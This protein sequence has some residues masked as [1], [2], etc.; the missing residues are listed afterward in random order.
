MR[1]LILLS[2]CIFIV[3]CT[4]ELPQIKP[5]STKN[6]IVSNDFDWKTSKEITVNVHQSFTG[7]ITIS[8]DNDSILFYK[9]Y[10]DGTE[11]GISISVTI[12][13]YLSNLK[14][15]DQI[16]TPIS[17]KV[18]LVTLDNP[19]NAPSKANSAIIKNYSLHLNGTTDWVSI[20][21]SQNLVFPNAFS[22]EAWVKAEH[23]QTAKII[24]KG[25]WDGFSIGEDLYKGWMTSVCN[26][27]MRATTLIWDKGQPVLNRWYHLAATYDGSLLKLYVD[28]VLVN[29]TAIKEKMNN[30]KRIIDIGCD[31]GNQKFFKGYMDNI[32]IW[33]TTLT[34][35]DVKYTMNT[36]PYGTGLLA[37][38]E[39]NEGSGTTVYNAVSNL[40]T[41]NLIGSFS[42]DLGYGI[43]SDGDGILNNYDDFPNDPLRAFSNKFPATGLG[44]LA[45]ED[46]WPGFG[47]FDFNDLVVEYQFD[48]ITNNKNKL[49]ETN[50]TFIVKAA[51]S[52][53][54]NGFGFQL[55][56]D[57]P[58]S[59]MTVT[60]SKLFGNI[61]STN[62]KGWE[63][64]QNKPTC[65]VFDNAFKCIK[66]PG[67]G[68]GVN[69]SEN[70][71]FVT[72]DTIKLHISYTPDKYT[73]ANLNI[74]RFNPFLIVNQIRSKEIHLADY[75]PTALVDKSYFDTYQDATD[76]NSGKYYRSST[77]LPWAINFY[78]KFDY[79]YEKADI[80]KA[81][82]KMASWAS[83]NGLN[84]SDWYKNKAGY[85]S[86]EY[87]Y[88]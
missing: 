82:P 71:T 60:G 38:W 19:Q 21:N 79:P 4:L 10:S 80:L 22:L 44:T 30:N 27:S 28:G 76:T 23:Q 35:S 77:N 26:D 18:D 12:P 31:N 20:P 57:I 47:D 25:D 55:T 13:S 73:V 7:V 62:P 54:Q 83:S 69:T 74:Q 24:Q 5:D 67:M 75:P 68:I 52:S 33:T 61:I 63:N 14:I 51:G 64:N 56:G 46:L 40:Y 3:S 86:I 65:I 58:Q 9:G 45:F 41:G 88:K 32:S 42:S 50:A 34:A 78:D 16:V 53:H 70:S 15:N 87:I 37:Y 6:L 49:V 66:F 8:S 17:N 85:S 48:N 36:T 2:I 39:F 84:Y 43:D 72:P 29:S 81:Y 1:N 59:D 11:T